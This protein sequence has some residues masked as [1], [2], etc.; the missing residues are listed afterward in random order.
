ML[1]QPDLALWSVTTGGTRYRSTFVSDASTVDGVT[2]ETRLERG[3]R[4]TGSLGGLLTA[5]VPTADAHTWQVDA[6]FTLRSRLGGPRDDET[7]RLVA[8]VPLQP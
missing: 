8:E 2:A 5:V 1:V 7:V 4:G 3:S 6:E